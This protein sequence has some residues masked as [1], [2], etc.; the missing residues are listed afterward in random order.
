M[1]KKAKNYEKTYLKSLHS[2]LLAHPNSSY[3]I[4][5]SLADRSQFENIFAMLLL[6]L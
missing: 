6:K 5:I 1:P 4:K 2:F 3:G